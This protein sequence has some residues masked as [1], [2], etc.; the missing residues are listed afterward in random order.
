[1]INLI[2][3]LNVILTKILIEF[4]IQIY[5]MIQIDTNKLWK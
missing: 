3:E 4:Q 1:M 2:T 5:N